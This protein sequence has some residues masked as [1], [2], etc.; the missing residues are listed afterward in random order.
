MLFRS[1]KIASDI[2][3]KIGF[4]G[5]VRIDFIISEKIYVLEL[6][7]VIV[8]G[9]HGSAYPFFEKQGI[10]IATKAINASLKILKEE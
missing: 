2:V 7:S 10:N 9:Y 3:R 5:L 4:S 1:C 8:T 6:N